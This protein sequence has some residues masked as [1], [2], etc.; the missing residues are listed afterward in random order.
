MK[1]IR[2]CILCA[3]F[4]CTA[5]MLLSGCGS[6]PGHA[7]E[8]SETETFLE[9]E[10]V[11]SA[12]K[13]ETSK[14][15]VPKKE[16]K[17]LSP[18][19]RQA[20]FRNEEFSVTAELTALQS[21]LYYPDIVHDFGA[22]PDLFAVTVEL[23]AKNM[24]EESKSF[25]ET[26]L[27]LSDMFYCGGDTEAF[28]E[29][30]SGKSAIGELRFLCS[31]E[32]AAAINGIL[33][34]GE[35][36]EEG[37]EFYP[38]EFNDIIDIQSSDDVSEYLYRQ[39]VIHG[40][41]SGYFWLN[42]EPSSCELHH[43]RA[44]EKDGKNYLAISYTFYNR[45]DYAQLIEPSAYVALCG[46]NTEKPEDLNMLA[47][48]EPIYI[49]TDEELMY[50]P[51]AAE[52][53]LGG[54]GQLYELPEYI[55][56]TPENPTDFTLIYDFRDY[57]TVIGLAFRSSHKDE[58]YYSKLGEFSEYGYVNFNWNAWEEKRFGR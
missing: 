14:R 57:L 12:A 54:V 48:A 35:Y 58:P 39:Y 7:G 17:P 21:S 44:V 47:S 8:Q 53:S 23:R 2:I 20:F 43:I 24:T 5:A 31:L 13:A 10:A 32:Q 25:D 27:L 45:S 11:T 22:N 51:R 38:E 49:S 1:K 34:D 33:Y 40:R 18:S 30:K 19:R 28:A 46:K 56:M 6:K 26:K 4:F 9:T 3:A 52:L 55:C 41:Q 15:E 50:E 42:T 16:I 29:I 36:L 37:E